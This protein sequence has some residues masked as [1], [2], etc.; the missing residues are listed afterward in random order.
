MKYDSRF[1]TGRFTHLKSFSYAIVILF[2]CTN[3][4]GDIKLTPSFHLLGLC[5]SKVEGGLH[6]NIVYD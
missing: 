5:F 4:D 1:L 6:Q 2:Y 3:T